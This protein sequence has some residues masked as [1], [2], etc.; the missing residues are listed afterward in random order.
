MSI[1]AMGKPYATKVVSTS[2]T[3]SLANTK[4]VAGRTYY[5]KVAFRTRGDGDSTSSKCSSVGFIA[6]WDSWKQ[7]RSY[8]HNSARAYAER[9][10]LV[11]WTYSFTVASDVQPTGTA[12][13][14][15]INNGW[16]N[17]YDNQTIDLYYAKYWDSAGNVYNEW[18]E[19]AATI[20]LMQQGKIYPAPF[21]STTKYA[22]PSLTFR[23]D[24]KTWYVPLLSYPSMSDTS[25]LTVE[26]GD[27]TY[28]IT[29]SMRSYF[30]PQMKVIFNN[31]MY[32]LPNG[33]SAVQKPKYDIP[34]GTYSPSAFAA[35][36]A[37]YISLNG[38][39]KCANEFTAKVNNQTITV[40]ANSTIYYKH[41]NYL[42][43]SDA[44]T[45]NKIGFGTDINVY[46]GTSGVHNIQDSNAGFKNYKQYIV[47]GPTDSNVV[48]FQ[49][50]ANY[51]IT[52][53]TGI[54]F[55]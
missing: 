13:Y 2:N 11:S 53:G 26:S 21:A 48:F 28:N 42:S 1:L 27:W 15:I 14:F 55:S 20:N 18:G 8:I 16:A 38:S 25:I 52:I 32:Y 47:R 41:D 51:P 40:A 37:N 19:E 7:A 24:G 29:Y 10:A 17:G 23:K 3:L 44:K 43:Y 49:Q 6:Y 46:T 9:G 36:I 39:R 54:N 50:Y 5:V 31:R 33:C 35:L 22:T 30:L 45:V 34:A 12:L 4:L